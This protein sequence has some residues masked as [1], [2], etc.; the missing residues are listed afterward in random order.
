[1]VQWLGLCSYTDSWLRKLTS[2]RPHCAAKKKKK[3]KENLLVPKLS[4]IKLS[5]FLIQVYDDSERLSQAFILFISSLR[6]ILSP[7]EHYRNFHVVSPPSQEELVLFESALSD[8]ILCEAP[9]PNIN[10]CRRSLG[11][12]RDTALSKSNLIH[13]ERHRLLTGA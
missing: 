9:A 4:C 1:M 8:Y 2:H 5:P 11:Q 10:P 7:R 3:E 12:T 6:L 13:V